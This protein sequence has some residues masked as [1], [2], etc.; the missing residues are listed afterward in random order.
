VVAGGALQIDLGGVASDTQV[1]GGSVF[2]SGGAAIRMHIQSGGNVATAVGG[3]ASGAVVGSGGTLE[4]GDNGVIRGA[5]VRAGGEVIVGFGVDEQGSAIGDVVWSSGIEV[6]SIGGATTGTR[7]LAGGNQYV[8]GSAPGEWLGGGGSDFVAGSAAG[9]VVESGG[10][11]TVLWGGV[12]TH[13]AVVSG[14]TMVVDSSGTVSASVVSGGVKQWATA[15]FVS[16]GGLTERVTVSGRGAS[17]GVNSGG[18][19]SGGVIEGDALLWIAQGATAEAMVISSNGIVSTYGT[20]D[21]VTIV[22]GDVQVAGLVSGGVVRGSGGLIVSSGGRA[23]D[24]TLSG[25]P[26]IEYIG[27]GGLVSGGAVEDGAHVYLQGSATAE[28]QFIDGGI[29]DTFGVISGDVIAGAN[30]TVEDGGTAEADRLTSRFASEYVSAGGTARGGSVANGAQLEVSSAGTAAAITVLS[31]G[32]LEVLSGGTADAV[33]AGRSGTVIVQSGASASFLSGN[34]L[35]VSAGAQVFDIALDPAQHF[36]GL[37][38]LV[39]ADAAGGTDIT[40]A[41]SST[42]QNG[43]SVLVVAVSSGGVAFAHS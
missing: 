13:A 24:V 33:L 30:L 15:L 19:A 18:T 8:F 26:I 2:I 20:L 40:L 3:V 31:G 5:S 23:Y 11:A 9:D 10:T 41:A 36:A 39:S 6:V 43:G 37:V 29:I 28:A 4:A 1:N 25:S 27:T 34:V 14:G 16:S 17:E 38:P 7:I 12:A 32:T 42:V 21:R 35:A 22:G